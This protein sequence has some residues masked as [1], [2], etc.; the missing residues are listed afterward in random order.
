MGITESGVK[1]IIKLKKDIKDIPVVYN[2]DFG[3]TE[4][5]LTLLIGGRVFINIR[6]NN[7]QIKV[8]DH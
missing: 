2:L 1:E 7:Y 3:H 6:G 4:P 5:K 8:L